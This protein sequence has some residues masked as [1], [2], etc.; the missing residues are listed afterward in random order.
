V[1]DPNAYIYEDIL[2]LLVLLIFDTAAV[3]DEVFREGGLPVTTTLAVYCQWLGQIQA[4]E[5]LN[6]Y[7]I[8]VAYRTLRR[9]R[10]V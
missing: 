10:V 3:R 1:I 2:K 6:L 7:W 5:V 4:G 9:R 8:P